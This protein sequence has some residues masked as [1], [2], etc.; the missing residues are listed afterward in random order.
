M[1]DETIEELTSAQARLRAETLFGGPGDSLSLRI[2]G[3]EEFLFVTPE[4][5]DPMTFRFHTT[6]PEAAE[7][8]AKIYR[9]RGDAG[10]VLIGQTPWSVALASIGA[11]IPTLFD[12]QARH[13][14]SAGKPIAMGRRERLL[15][16]LEGGSNVAI[17]GERRICIGSTPSRVVFNAELF[18]KCA[19]AF[20]IAHAGGDRVRKLPGWVRYIAGARL[21]RDQRR[22][23]SSYAAGRIPEGMDA[24]S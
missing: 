6:G 19:Y 8:H 13:I 10:G 16:A 4:R 15:R 5:S 21:R 11:R 12:E 14:G 17:Y 9:S 24:Y 3:R 2:P 22:A 20:V 7:L 1:T 18:E 23:A